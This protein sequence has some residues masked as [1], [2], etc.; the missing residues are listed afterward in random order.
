MV[1]TIELVSKLTFELFAMSIG[2]RTNRTFDLMCQALPEYKIAVNM[3]E[4]GLTPENIRDRLATIRK[5]HD[6]I[7]PKPSPT[8]EKGRSH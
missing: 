4:K 5:A 6:E 2:E 7:S 8:K 3:M 1:L